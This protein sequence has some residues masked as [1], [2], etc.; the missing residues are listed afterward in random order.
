[1][2]INLERVEVSLPAVSV[3][4]KITMQPLQSERQKIAALSFVMGS[5]WAE[6]QLKTLEQK[7]NK[8]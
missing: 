5:A 8:S 1:M 4:G 6:E 3:E 2:S 7:N